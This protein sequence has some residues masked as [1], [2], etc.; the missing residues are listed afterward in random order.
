MSLVGRRRGTCAFLAIALTLALG[1]C[2]KDDKPAAKKSETPTPATTSPAPKKP[3]PRSPLTGLA[4]KGGPPKHPV[5]VVKIDNTAAA[6]PQVGL[7]RADIVVEELVEGGLTRLAAL[8]YARTPK[9][10]GPVRSMRATDIG[11]AKPTGGTLIASGGASPTIRRIKAARV[12]VLSEDT[13]TVGLFTKDPNR[14]MPYNR[15][16]DL[17]DLS[18]K[19]KPAKVPHPYLPFS[20]SDKFASKNKATA[21]TVSFGTTQ[22]TR[23]AFGNGR[24]SRQNG[25]AAPGR[26]F[27]ADNLLVLTVKIGDAGYVDAAGSPVPETIFEGKGKAQLYH[28]GRVVRARWY[29]KGR[30]SALSLKTLDGKSLAV[31]PGRTW[32]ELMPENTGSITITKR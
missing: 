7:N 8:F 3:A 23:W 19:A 26:D 20:A 25:L 14:R 6:N 24:W 18:A 27:K 9:E 4:F 1:A 11:I 32:I 17:K 5:Y 15:I 13:G 12:K 28:D 31:P 30:S 29:K 22:Q 10:I 2:S 16:L 21:V